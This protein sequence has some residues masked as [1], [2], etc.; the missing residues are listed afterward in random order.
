MITKVFENSNWSVHHDDIA[1]TYLVVAPD[2]QTCTA[3]NVRFL[4]S[5]SFVIDH[6]VATSHVVLTTEHK[7]LPF[8]FQGN[9]EDNKAKCIE[10][11]KKATGIHFG[12]YITRNSRRGSNIPY[13]G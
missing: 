2:A 8:V 6:P 13:G 1:N 12:G 11:L 5:E 4:T 10:F 7:E 3:K 9:L